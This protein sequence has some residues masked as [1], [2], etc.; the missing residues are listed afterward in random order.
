M[1]ENPRITEFRYSGGFVAHVWSYDP[2]DDEWGWYWQ[3]LKDGERIN[4]GVCKSVPDGNHKA[5]AAR[6]QYDRKQF[7]LEFYYDYETQ[8]WYR[9]GELVP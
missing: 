1:A 5:I 8:R 6:D 2:L 3:L 9:K 4:G 7:L